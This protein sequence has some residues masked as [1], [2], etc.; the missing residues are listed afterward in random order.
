ML[1]SM[2]VVNTGKIAEAGE[3]VNTDYEPI[4]WADFNQIYYPIVVCLKPLGLWSFKITHNKW[5]LFTETDF[6][7]FIN[8]VDYDGSNFGRDELL[9]LKQKI[10]K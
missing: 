5:I 2:V 10:F 8:T 1:K 7:S 9:G 3:I 4:G 6:D